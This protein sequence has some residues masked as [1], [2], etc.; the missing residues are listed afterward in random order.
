MNAPMRR[1]SVRTIPILALLRRDALPQ[2]TSQQLV[3]RM[4]EAL[5]TEHA[6]EAR[7]KEERL[8]NWLEQQRS[9]LLGFSGGVDSAYLGS[10]AVECLG[11]DRILAVIGRSPSYPAVQWATARDVAERV[12]LPI[13]ELDTHEM[14][15]PRYAAN[16]TNRCYFCKTELWTVLE[17]VA[18]ERGFA[19]IVDGSNADD[20]AD[21]RPGTRAAKS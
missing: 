11:P 15:D 6:K 4:D 1:D 20:R 5:E 14:D 13:L 7:R 17:S 2:L 16:P 8:A 9:V 21:W 12:G 18:S 19:M 3:C 10:V